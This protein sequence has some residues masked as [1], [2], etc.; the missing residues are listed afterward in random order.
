MRIGK[1]RVRNYSSISG[2]DQVTLVPG[3]TTVPGKN[4][5]G[6]RH[7]LRALHSFSQD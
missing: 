5:C 3:M 7:T 6:K 2:S 1:F 4:E